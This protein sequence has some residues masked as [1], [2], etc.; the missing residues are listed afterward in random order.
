M[1]FYYFIQIVGKLLIFNLTVSLKDGDESVDFK[2]NGYC[3]TPSANCLQEIQ[4]SIGTKNT[5]KILSK[6]SYHQE[7]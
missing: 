5:A 7:L 3:V 4:A 6:K 2:G 1:K